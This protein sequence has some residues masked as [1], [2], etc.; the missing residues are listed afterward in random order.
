MF[1][2]TLDDTPIGNYADRKTAKEAL[3]A[4]QHRGI[5]PGRLNIVAENEPV[6]VLGSAQYDNRML[7]IGGAPT[8]ATTLPT[9]AKDRKE[10]PIASG[11]MDYFPDAIV[12]VSNLSYRGN[13]QHNPGQPLH[14]ARSKSADEAD[15]MLRH[16]LQRGTKDTD[17]V[18][19]TVKMAWRALAL[20]Q[21][22][23]EAERGGQ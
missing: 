15:T 16:F 10:Y 17:G 11:F 23:L 18:R 9:E 20:L 21:K 3:V 12:A 2:L 1:V 5:A 22:E 13:Q 7:G 19:H 8:R 14:W 4:E 6:I